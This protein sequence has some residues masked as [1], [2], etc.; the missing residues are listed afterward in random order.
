MKN[1]SI[2]KILNLCFVALLFLNRQKA[3]INVDNK[4]YQVVPYDVEKPIKLQDIKK[5]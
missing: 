3:Y 4:V 1:K 2:S 5:L